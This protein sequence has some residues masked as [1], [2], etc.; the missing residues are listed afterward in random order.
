MIC[1]FF[2]SFCG[3]S[4][5]NLNLPQTKIMFSSIRNDFTVSYKI[6]R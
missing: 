5:N 4:L 1:N 3:C 6:K 2:F